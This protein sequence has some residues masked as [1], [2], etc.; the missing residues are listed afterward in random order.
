[1]PPKR[2]GGSAS[3]STEVAPRDDAMLLRFVELLSEETVVEKLRG[4]FSPRALTDKLDLLTETIAKLNDRLDKKD[5]YIAALE[6]RLSLVEDSLDQLEQYSRR[7][8]LRFFGI[9]ESDGGEDTT[10][11]LLAIVNETMGVT[12]P[13]VSADVVTSHRLGRRLPGADAHAR[14]RPV[15]VKFATT[16]V[17]DVVIRARR[18]LRESGRGPTLYVNEDLTRRRATLAKKTRELKKEKKITDCWTYNGKV[19]V[20]IIDGTVKEI[21]ADIDLS[22]Y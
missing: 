20:K 22:G 6:A 5:I 12:P 9:P 4:M 10:G 3:D 17:R 14:P 15:I 8:N 1:M 21:R 18:R 2:R 19:L 13:I 7:S 11:K 16:H